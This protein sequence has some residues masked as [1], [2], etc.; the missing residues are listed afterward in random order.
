[1]KRLTLLIVALVMLFSCREQTKSEK[2]KLEPSV[3]MDKA[4]KNDYKIVLAINNENPDSIGF[5]QSEGEA[6]GIEGIYLFEDKIV[7]TDPIH[8]NLKI[9]DVRTNEVMVSNELDDGIEQVI[10]FNNLLYVF[11]GSGKVFLFDRGLEYDKELNLGFGSKGILDVND[12]SICF[13]N[14]FNGRKSKRN[15]ISEVIL[16]WIRL[17]NTITSDTLEMSNEVF[18]EY[19]LFG[20]KYQ[21]VEK[22]ED[23][24]I[25]TPSFEVSFPKQDLQVSSYDT[26]S[27][28]FNSTSFCFFNYYN[29]NLV[30]KCLNH[31]SK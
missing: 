6:V 16:S 10:E 31:L 8:K 27:Y 23:I 15:G 28:F 4:L 17:D 3:S 13:F 20:K 22:G 26:Q 12:T 7:L 19:N 1:M 5:L 18:D 14:E 24:I 9:I 11:S 25:K 21:Y 29:Q 30:I 2:S